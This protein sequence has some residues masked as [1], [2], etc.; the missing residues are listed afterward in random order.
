VLDS[1]IYFYDA[2]EAVLLRYAQLKRQLQQDGTKETAYGYALKMAGE[3][4]AADG[5]KRK[6]TD[7]KKALPPA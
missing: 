5:Q 2:D 6:K 4:H 7:G 1:F 3:L